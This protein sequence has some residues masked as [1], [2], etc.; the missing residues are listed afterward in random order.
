MARLASI[1]KTQAKP[2][3]KVKLSLGLATAS[4][5]MPLI[6]EDAAFSMREPP[7]SWMNT[8]MSE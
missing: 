6:V 1:V 3:F 8:C 7:M 5:S 2:K 4:I